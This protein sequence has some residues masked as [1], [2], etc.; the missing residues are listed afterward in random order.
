M[1]AQPPGELLQEKKNLFYVTV[2]ALED[3]ITNPNVDVADF[4]SNYGASAGQISDSNV[5][6]LLHVVVDLIRLRPHLFRRARRIIID[7][8]VKEFPEL[9]IGLNSDG[10]NP[11]HLAI[12]DQSYELFLHIDSIC[13]ESGSAVVERYF[14]EALA[15]SC[16]VADRTALH[17]YFEKARHLD[18]QAAEV[19]IQHA[20]NEQLAAQDAYGNTPMHYAASFHHCHLEGL[21][22]VE[23]LIDR[24]DQ[25]IK[26]G[27]G[28]GQTSFLEIRN[29]NGY[30]VYQTLAQSMNGERCR[31]NP[32][33][34]TAF[35]EMSLLLKKHYMRTRGHRE[36]TPFLYGQNVDDIEISF[37]YDNLPTSINRRDF[38]D[39]FGQDSTSGIKLDS[40]LQSVILPS[41][42][43]RLPGEDVGEYITLNDM[44]PIFRWLHA[45]GVRHV[46]SLSVDDFNGPRNALQWCLSQF[47]IEILDWQREDMDLEV[48]YKAS[49][50]WLERN[51]HNG[52]H[53]LR[54]LWLRWSGRSAVLHSWSRRKGLPKFLG[55]E[56]VYLFKPERH[57]TCDDEDHIEQAI[58]QFRE[59]LAENSPGIEVIVKE[60]VTK[61]NS[62]QESLATPIRRGFGTDSAYDSDLRRHLKSASSFSRPLKEDWTAIRQTSASTAGEDVVVA[63]IGDGVDIMD[64]ALHNQCLIGKSFDY[65][66]PKDGQTREVFLPPFVSGSDGTVMAN[67]ILHVCPMA[68]IYPIRLPKAGLRVDADSL[69]EAIEAALAKKATIISLPRLMMC[70]LA[71]DGP[72]K[73]K[74]LRAL[75]RVQD[76]NALM[77]C[78]T[79]TMDIFN[80]YPKGI[81]FIDDIFDLNDNR[82]EHSGRYFA[83]PGLDF[84]LSET[85]YNMSD[86]EC[87]V[88]G[89]T[90]SFA[91]FKCASPNSVST[92]LATGLAAAVIY[93]VKLGVMS[94]DCRPDDADALVNFEFA[95]DAAE[96]VARP[97]AMARVF[98]SLCPDAKSCDL[99]EVWHS[100]NRRMSALSMTSMWSRRRLFLVITSILLH[101]C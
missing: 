89:F 71:Q 13:N 2:Q 82:H 53:L 39:R 56:R 87:F 17:T 18:H 68:K 46:M 51:P 59:E 80:A 38:T 97:D 12:K 23:M 76:E 28:S 31:E 11:V 20:T 60:A 84:P 93:L 85:R 3:A 33:Q 8:L 98:R 55:L 15:Q 50:Q 35:Q 79:S 66:E 40:V 5:G 9:L 94:N 101:G 19:L 22:V 48:I 54:E 24:D 26:K 25:V 90:R 83:F 45:K 52:H 43:I 73:D 47:S 30:S 42:E 36:A 7:K 77:F 58:A 62:R 96:T 37:H 27:G 21:K 70:V 10:Y 34:E 86:D 16:S 4:W 69:A 99:G 49:L 61:S 67:L 65:Q 92:A 78:S 41:I 6:N 100:L 1:R 81:L 91:N 57:G 72:G 44:T 74:L 32:L 88:D 29:I 14:D 95:A 64:E 75:K 63:V